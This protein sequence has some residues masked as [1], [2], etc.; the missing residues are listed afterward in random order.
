[1]SIH[2]A[3]TRPRRNI[4]EHGPAQNHLIRLSQIPP[5]ALNHWKSSWSAKAKNPDDR[6]GKTTAGRRLE[7]VKRFLNYCVEMRWLA[8]NPAAE[9]KA[10]KPDPSVTWPLLG[11]RYEKG[12]RR[13][14]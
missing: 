11:G 6:I 9:L 2:I 10:I 14:L 7:K 12:D 5:D 13:D 4:S 3:N 8:A 1:M